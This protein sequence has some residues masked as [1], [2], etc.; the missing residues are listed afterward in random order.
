MTC[1]RSF[2]YYVLFNFSFNVSF[3][4]AVSTILYCSGRCPFIKQFSFCSK[5][6][7]QRSRP[8]KMLS[9]YGSCIT[10]ISAWKSR[11]IW[12]SILKTK[13]IVNNEI[14]EC[15]CLQ[16]LRLFIEKYPSY[17]GFQLLSRRFVSSLIYIFLRCVFCFWHV[18]ESCLRWIY[19]LY[20]L[21]VIVK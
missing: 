20:C 19:T 15:I 16:I 21:I 5:I 6:G 7:I 12:E 4:F 9:F 3:F 17:K 18:F 1:S 8:D 14:P 10:K 2:L 11:P 13:G